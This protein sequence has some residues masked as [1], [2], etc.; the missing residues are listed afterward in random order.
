M[1][2]P[3]SWGAF[4][5]EIR[6]WLVSV[7]GIV[8]D[9]ALD[10]VLAVQL[11]LLPSRDRTF[12]QV[13]A[14]AHDYVAW[15]RMLL[16][17]RDGNHLDWQG[18]LSPLRSFPPGSLTVDDPHDICSTA[19]DGSLTAIVHESSWDFESPVSRP[20]QRRKSELEGAGA[21]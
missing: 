21:R 6:R 8:D 12:P 16:V 10:T 11:A 19:L 9:D 5:E 18:R 2:P 4:L 13:I 14:L 3:V 17:E 1:V 15:R 7:E 20:R